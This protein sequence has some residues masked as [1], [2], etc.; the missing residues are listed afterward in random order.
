MERQTILKEVGTSKKLQVLIDTAAEI[1]RPKV[2][3]QFFTQVDHYDIKFETLLGASG[4]G[5]AAS[6]VAYDSSAPLRT[7]KFIG[8]VTGDIPSI[9]EKFRMSESDFLKYDIMASRA[10]TSELQ[11]LKLIFDDVRNAAEAPHKRLDWIVLEALSTGKCTLT[12]TNNPDGMV[13]ETAVDFAVPADNKV[14]AAVVW[15]SAS[16]ATPI[17]DFNTIR[18]L[19]EANGH[20]LKR[21]LMTR[22]AWN[23][24]KNTTEVINAIKGYVMGQKVGTYSV[25]KDLVNDFL[26]ANDLPTISIVNVSIGIEKSGVITN[27]NPWSVNNVAFITGDNMGDMYYGPIAERNHKVDQVVYAE[28]DGVLIK[29]W[30]ETDPIS[31]FTGCELNAFPSWKTVDSHYLLNTAHA[32]TFE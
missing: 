24:F 4:P 8:K 30:G 5:A 23:A 14:G 19:A 1:Y 13:W 21:A 17:V 31:E 9:R 12:T 22:T 26:L 18:D 6:I 15:S 20:T 2:W 16:T 11:L 10:S 7:R 25:T 27:Y 32:T 29:K 3:P 28:Y